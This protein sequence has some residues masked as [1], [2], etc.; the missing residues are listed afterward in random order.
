MTNN[1]YVFYN[2]LSKRYGDVFCAPTDDFASNFVSK[3][4]SAPNSSLIANEVEVCRIACVDIE[5]GTVIAES[6][7]VRIDILPSVTVDK[8]CT[9]ATPD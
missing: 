8:L 7:P 2:R 3:A 9:P 6:A 1:I 5:R 4:M